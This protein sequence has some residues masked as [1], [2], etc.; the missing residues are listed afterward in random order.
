MSVSVSSSPK[1]PSAIEHKLRTVRWRHAIATAVFALAFS[2]CVL[3]TLMLV[4][5]LVDWAFPFLST[6]W[7]IALTATTLIASVS[8]FVV[9]GLRPIRHALGWNRAATA[10]DEEIPAL[11]ERWSTVASLANRNPTT[12]TPIELAMAA[13]VTSEAIALERI[14]QPSQVAPPVTTRPALMALGG[15]SLLVGLMFFASPTQMTVLLRRFWSPTSTITA[16]QLTS[17]TGDQVVPRGEKIELLTKLEGLPRSTATLTIRDQEGEEQTLTLRASPETPMQFAHTMRIDGS[18]MY[19]VRAGDGQT[20]WHAIDA[21][22]YPEV[23]AIKFQIEFPEYTQRE[24]VVRDRIPRRVKVIQGSQ[25]FLSIKPIEPLQKLAVTLSDPASPRKQS[26]GEQAA[27]ERMHELMPTP[28]GWYRF[29]MPLLDDVLIE[30]TMTSE[31]GLTNLRRL[32][33]RIDVIADKAPV[34]RVVSPTDEMAVTADETIEIEFEAHDDHGIAKAELVV[35][36][37]SQKDSEGNPRI[38]DVKE[39]PLGDEQMQKHVMGT[40][41]L[42]L[43]ELD[44]EEGSEISYAIRVTDNRNVTPEEMRTAASQALAGNTSENREEQTPSNSSD[45]GEPTDG[46]QSQNAAEQNV[47]SQDAAQRQS[48]ERGESQPTDSL[49][50]MTQMV[51]RGETTDTAVASDSEPNE[52][53]INSAATTS[54]MQRIAANAVAENKGEERELDPAETNNETTGDPSI[55]SGSTDAN[56]DLIANTDAAETDRNSAG[57]ANADTDGEAMADRGEQQSGS[58]ASDPEPESDVARSSSDPSASAQQDSESSA[59]AVA[60]SENAGNENNSENNSPGGADRQASNDSMLAD[61]ESR[62]PSNDATGE[63]SD[64]VDPSDNEES[65]EM[66][67]PNSTSGDVANRNQNSNNRA[68]QS[69]Q[70]PTTL[71][72]QRSRSGQNTLTNRRRLKVTERLAAIAEAEDRPGDELEVRKNVVDIDIMLAQIEAGLHQLVDR[73]IADADRAEQFR[74]LDEGMGNVETYVA[75]LREKTRDNQYAFVGLQMVDIV[76]THVTPAR[77]RVFAAIQR[78]NARDADAAV[79]LQHIVRAR[80]LLAALLK[81]YDRVV[82]EQKL[83][84]SLDETVTMYEVYLEK[85][86]ML[87]REARQNLNP[88][89]RKMAIIEVDQAYLDRLA[90][91]LRLRREMMDEFARMLGDDPRLLSRYMELIKRRGTSLRDR[92]TEISES[93]YESTEETLGW[94][95]VDESQRKDLWTIIVDLRLHAAGEMAKDA[96]EL[97]ERIQKQMPLEVDVQVGTA[98]EVARQAQQVSQI[99]RS[100]SFDA[101]SLL[102]AG[103]SVEDRAAVVGRARLLIS[104]LHQLSALLDRFEVEFDQF[105]SVANYVEPRILELRSVLA[106]ADAWLSLNESITANDYAGIVRTEQYRLAVDTQILRVEMLDMKDDLE[107]QFRQLAESSLPTDIATMIDQLHHLM[108]SITFNQIAASIRS[109]GSLLDATAAQQQ[110][111][112]ER[113]EQA[114]ELFDRIR[115]AVAEEL[116]Q[117]DVRNPNIAD[118]QDPTLDEFLAQLEREPDIVRQLGIPNRRRNLRII[119][120]SVAW[121]QQ[122]GRGGLAD[123]GDAA[124]QRA[125]DAMMMQRKEKRQQDQPQPQTQQEQ[126][127]REREQQAQQMLEKTLTELQRQM[128]D[129]E[130]SEEQRQRLQQISEEMQQLMEQSENQEEGQQAWTRLVQ[131]DQTRAIMEAIAQGETI[132]DE[133]WNKLLST[134]DEGLWQVRGKEPPEA[135]RKAIEQYQDQIRELMKTIDE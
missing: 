34:A 123:S 68:M 16:S 107:G 94:L 98:A 26:D 85:R 109:R 14:V 20:Q 78:P 66:Q 71:T 8:T 5:V 105:D 43:K 33:S 40:T 7:R 130:L 29:E 76:R 101:E 100:V 102:D 17:L 122:N 19:R 83:Q 15:C 12:Q 18:L 55:E 23:E 89:E 41:T 116:D 99:A 13:Q 133:Q 80:E 112:T 46:S 24:S 111:A 56:E 125:A 126:E 127:Q 52:E 59:D 81:R 124:A 21:I 60:Q 93:Q 42:D 1:F 50:E 117:Y 36:D 38:V 128:Q 4:A 51:P 39:I 45:A 79:A 121:Q 3:I 120:D 96:S 31:H 48:A 115:R 44:L 86:R 113:L 104:Q 72:A 103:S 73:A 132:P 25:L 97:S 135:Y 9:L 65:S 70:Q 82:Q 114:E 129:P 88:M 37:E 95:Q 49:T 22:D 118:L 110:L 67:N 87:M 6:P 35:Y 92:L 77:D 84:E 30:S 57:L 90:E 47:A 53:G 108:E 2:I 10:V 119:S 63:P 106:Q 64:R 32:F 69:S 28:D 75:E 62:Q 91:V 134:L 61:N 11:E 54:D 74:R 131:S 27:G 58:T